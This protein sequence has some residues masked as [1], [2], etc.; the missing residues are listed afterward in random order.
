MELAEEENQLAREIAEKIIRPKRSSYPPEKCTE[1]NTKVEGSLTLNENTPVIV[2]SHGNTG[3]KQSSCRTAALMRNEK[4]AVVGFDFSGCGNS[5]GQYVTMGK[6]EINDLEDVIEHIKVKFGF[7][8]IALYGRSMGGGISVMYAGRHPNDI[9]GVGIDAPFC[10]LDDFVENFAYYYSDKAN[11]NVIEKV[12]QIIGERI[13]VKKGDIVP[14]QEAKLA[15]APLYIGHGMSDR[16]VPIANAEKII[17]AYG[18]NDKK[19]VRFEGDHITKRPQIHLDT[20]R[21]F[22][23]RVLF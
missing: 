17:A 15:S 10:S 2:C 20:L 11:D 22:F 14:F 21:E 19:L 18:S 3:D 9:V 7:K 12:W 23:K 5:G 8:K 1:M 13:G 6:N 4:V 16:L